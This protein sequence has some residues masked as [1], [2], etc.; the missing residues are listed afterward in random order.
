MRTSVFFFGTWKLVADELWGLLTETHGA[1]KE[2]GGA[3]PSGSNGVDI[4]P[5]SS[6]CSLQQHC[7]HLGQGGEATMFVR[8][9][10]VLFLAPG[11]G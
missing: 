9:S 8:G 2:G 11:A 7:S 6:P 1:I 4:V 5:A 10:S 3:L